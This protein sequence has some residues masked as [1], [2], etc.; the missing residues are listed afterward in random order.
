MQ[1]SNKDLEVLFG[2]YL[3]DEISEELKNRFLTGRRLPKTYIELI[4]LVFNEVFKE[5]DPPKQVAYIARLKNIPCKF[6]NGCAIFLKSYELKNFRVNLVIF[7]KKESPE[8]RFYL[9]KGDKNFFSLF[10]FIKTE[11]IQD[12]LDLLKIILHSQ[13]QCLEGLKRWINNCLNSNRIIILEEI[14]KLSKI[15]NEIAVINARID[16]LNSSANKT[17]KELLNSVYETLSWNE[18]VLLLQEDY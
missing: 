8:I 7:Y 17:Q 16:L 10:Q 1:L 2:V 3:P 4:S 14:T 13:V 18:K 12:Y 5:G 11:D 15:S 6:E 9:S